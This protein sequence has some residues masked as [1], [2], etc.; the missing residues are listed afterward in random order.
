[1]EYE[2]RS[3]SAIKRVEYDFEMLY[4]QQIEMQ[5]ITNQK[6]VSIVKMHSKFSEK[7]YSSTSCIFMTPTNPLRKFLITMVLNSKF[8]GFILL[9]IVLNCLLLAI[10][11]YTSGSWKAT[12]DTVLVFVFLGEAVLKIVAMGFLFGKNS[13]LTDVWNWLDFFVVVTGVLSMIAVGGNLSVIRT[14]RILRPLRT[15]NTI[16]EMKVLIVSILSSLPLL[17]DVFILLIFFMLIFSLIAVQLYGGAFSNNCFEMGGINTGV[18]CSIDPGCLEFELNCGN[19]GCDVNQY[20]WNSRMNPE[21]G[22]TNFDNVPMSFLT[23]YQALTMEGWSDTMRHGRRA[24]NQTFL[25]DIY[26]F[27]LIIIG[28]F[29]LMNFTVAAVVIKF[30]E[31]SNEQ[32]KTIKL[33]EGKKPKLD[34]TPVKP[35]APKD[36]KAMKVYKFRIYVS[37]KINTVWFGNFIMFAIVLNTLMMASEY[38]GMTQLHRTINDDLNIVLNV[39]F[40]AEMILKLIALGCKGYLSDKMNIFDGFVVLIGMIEIILSGQGV[41]NGLL[42]LR[43]FRMLRIFKLSRKWKNLRNMLVKLIRSLKSIAYLGLLMLI[44]LFI[45]TLLGKQ[46]FKDKL[47]DANGNNP[48]ANF[49][50]LFWSFVTV[51][52][53]T[54]LQNWNEILDNTVGSVGSIYAIYFITL[55]IIGNT[56]S[57]NLLLA[58]LIQQFE[59]DDPPSD[60]EDYEETNLEGANEADRLRRRKK[61]KKALNLKE[62]DET[63]TIEAIPLHGNSLCVF[64]KNNFFRKIL[65]DLIAHPYFDSTVYSLIM[66]SCFALAIDEPVKFSYTMRFVGIVDNFILGVFTAEVIVKSIVLGLIKGKNSYL[67]NSW[68]RLDFFIVFISYVELFLSTVL[69]GSVNSSYLKGLRALRAL[70]PLR[71]V[72][73]N[74]KM[75]KVVTSIIRTFPALINVVAITVLFYL[76]FAILGVIFFSGSMYYCTDPNI[77]LQTECIGYFTDSNGN[78]GFR[79]WRTVSYNFD[80]VFYGMLALFFVSANGSWPSYMYA[81][82]D[83]VGPGRAMSRDYNQAAGLFYIFYIFF[84]NYFI[85]VLFLG[86]IVTNFNAIQKELDGSLFLTNEQ[87][88]WVQT[89]RLMI[90]CSPKIKFL[91]PKNRIRGLF[92]DFIMNYKFDMVIETCIILNVAFMTLVNFPLDKD[93]DALLTIANLVFVVIFTLEMLSKMIGK[94]IRYYFA[95]NWNTF[96]CIVTIVSIISLMP[97]IK[98][99]NAAVLRTF[100]IARLFRLVKMYKGFQAIINTLILSA[101]S[102]INV[103]ALLGLLWFVYSVAGMK[104][105]GKFDYTYAQVVNDEQ[106]FST[107]YNS[108]ALVVQC[109][110]GENYDLIMYDYAG[111]PDCQGSSDVC[112]SPVFATIFFVSYTVLGQLMILNMFVAVILENFTQEEED[113]TLAGL[114]QKD[115]KKFVKAW[116]SYAPHGEYYISTT[117]LPALLLN[118]DMPLGFKGQNLNRTQILQIIAALNIKDF[119]GRVHFGDILWAL[120]SSVDGSDLEKAKSCEAVQNI[121]KAVPIRFPIFNKADK[122]QAFVKEEISAAKILSGRIIWKAWKLYKNK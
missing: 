34:F 2:L 118:V 47:N 26:F 51:F 17:V 70:R 66:L 1:M 117:F 81:V 19:T 57:L 99:G 101:P 43:A 24:L 78:P 90:R 10:D 29:F 72:S 7:P 31:S 8:D 109:I 32:R 107:F 58:I 22:I 89:Q 79:S 121:M 93:L 42:V 12:I 4:N 106:N 52:N 113:L 119:K 67:K 65:R 35:D 68:N 62:D 73:Q 46:L 115:L 14:V 112:G 97:S 71:F 87:K 30:K 85:M 86:A 45:Y 102:L 11:D 69:S 61:R 88:N 100:R 63:D 75:K 111:S 120:A 84:V 82:V 49:D 105:F 41:L 103:G 122:K 95:D 9:I 36:S 60:E 16:P 25:N 21:Q 116:A 44:I 83:A 92:Y 48:R 104:L 3:L 98:F 5:R 37:E 40:L 64:N 74:E 96:D 80:N 20:C 33:I 77:V 27:V 114:Y 91:R 56:I 54:T 108:F 53:I 28:S 39:I 13:Y 55:I 18:L 6:D 23:I 50:N 110:T 59:T 94:G 76:I 15:I 38:Y